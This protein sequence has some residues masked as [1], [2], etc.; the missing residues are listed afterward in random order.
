VD[1]TKPVIELALPR[2]DQAVNGAFTLAGTVRDAVGIKRL[3][4]DFAGTTK[5]EIPLRAG[6]PYF[7][8]ELDALPLKGPTA[9]IVLVAED[10]IGNKTV[11]AIAPKIDRE[12]DKPR[13]LPVFPQSEGRVRAGEQVWGTV[14]D[15]DGVASVRWSVDGGAPAEAPAAEAFAFDLPDLASGRHLL[16]LTAVDIK[17]TS[18]NPKLLP[19][20]YDRGR[21]S[22]SFGRLAAA[23]GSKAPTAGRDFSQGIEVAV[24]GGEAL[25]GIV[26]MPNPPAKAEWRIGEGQARKLEL[27][28]REKGGKEARGGDWG[29]RIPLDRSLPFGFAA[30]SVRVQDSF[31]NEAAGEA[32]IYV[33]NY[34]A[35]REETGFRF[36][37]GRAA[38]D[39]SIR[40]G[41]RDTLGGVFFREKLASLK[42]EPPTQLVQASFAGQIVTIAAANE[43]RTGLTR[44]VAMT[45]R[46]HVFS[47]GPFDFVTDLEPPAVS[48]DS[49]GQGAWV[50]D[51]LPVSGR[52]D[53]RNGLA[54][55]SWRLLPDGMKTEL[56][57]AADGRFSFTLGPAEL[58]GLSG[59]AT[60]E[61]EALDASGNAG[62]A[63][64]AFGVS[65]E[66]PKL[67]FICPESGAEVW[68]PEDIAAAISAAS[69]I[70][71]VEY[72]DDGM[73]FAAI[74][75]ADGYFAHR[76]DLAAHPLATY[77]V[78]DRAGNAA[79]ARPQVRI[80]PAP[81]LPP[82]GSPTQAG[83]PSIVLLSPAKPGA[84]YPGRLPL[85]LKI[86]APGGLASAE[87]ATGADKKPL[88][89]DEGGRYFV[90]MLDPAAAAKSGPLAILVSAKDAAGKTA[91]LSLRLGYDAM[92][93]TPRPVLGL[94]EARYLAAGSLLSCE[95]ADDDGPCE[96]GLSIDGAETARSAAGSIAIALPALAA[97]KHVLSLEARDAA[98]RSAGIKKEILALGPAPSLGAIE[99]GDAKTKLPWVPGLPVALA[100]ASYLSGQ[101]E[102]PN[103]IAA[104][105]CRIGDRQLPVSVGKAAT[106][107]GSVPFSLA[108]PQQGFGPLTLSLKARDAAGLSGSRELLIVSVMTAAAGEDDA[109]GLR[110]ADARI[111]RA[112]PSVLLSPGDTL[113]GRFKGRG[114]RSVA[115]KPAT[116][117][118]EAGFE[119]PIVSLRAKAEGIT[120][121]TTVRV[122]TVDGDAFEW[123]PAVFRIDA[124]PPELELAS[125]A[126]GLWVQESLRIAG[127]ARDPLGLAFVGYSIDGGEPQELPPAQP[128]AAGP[129]A[130]GFRFDQAIQLPESDGA[131][132]VEVVARDRTGKES[133]AA[134]LFAKDTRP[135]LISQVLP[136][137]GSSVNGLFTFVAEASDEGR[138][139]TIVFGKSEEVEG[140]GTF[141]KSLDANR[142]DFPLAEGSL[143]V[144][145]DKAGNASAFSPELSVDSEADLPVAAIHVPL[146][147]EVLRQDF[148]V[149]GAAYDDDGLA[150]VYYRLDGGEWTRLALEGQSFSLLLGLLATG[151]N[152]HRVEVKAEDVYGIV[153]KSVSRKFRIST[154]EPFARLV[155]PPSAKVLS[156]IV[157]LE[158]SASDANGVSAMAL[159]FDS[160]ASFQAPAGSAS[161]RYR[162]D[163]RLLD[164]GARAISL[165]P[166]DGYDTVGFTAALLT[167]DNS[168]PEAALDLPLDGSEAARELLVSGRVS[169]N[170]GLSSARVEILPA[171]QTQSVLSADIGTGRVVRKVLD[172]SGLK[173]GVYTVRLV[174]RDRAGNESLA[175]RDIRV[176][177]ALPEDSIEVLYP[178]PGSSVAGAIG[179][180]GRARIA[181]PPASIEIL[182]DGQ[183]VASAASGPHGYFS[184][185]LPPEA[186]A[187][188]AHRLGAR[189]IA[190]DGRAITAPERAL[191]WKR[192]GP[193]VRIESLKTGDFVPARPYLR[194]KAGMLRDAPDPSDA[195]AV[196]EFR[197]GLKDRSVASVELSLDGGLSYH[198]AEGKENWRFRMETQD[199]REGQLH[200][201]VRASFGDGSSA[202]TATILS[203][204]KTAPRV[205]MLSPREGE[206]QNEKIIVIGST[207]D[208]SG[209]ESVALALRKGDKKSYQLPAFIQ[210][211]YVDGH[212]LGATTW[213]AGLGLTFF[214]DNVKLQGDYG[215]APTTDANGQAQ[216]FFGTVFGAKLIANL[217]YVPFNYLFGPDWEFLSFSFGLGANFTYFSET[218]SGSGLLVGAVF[219]QIEFPKIVMRNWG[220]F[221]KFSFYTEA[222]VWVLS[223]VVDGGFIPKL[224]FGARIGVF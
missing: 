78:T 112:G 44:L 205:E 86:E 193:W 168:P 39:G 217:A 18:G 160:G 213:E 114:I 148:L 147:D 79:L 209:I 45:E 57:P 88:P 146:E 170:L 188:G 145:K 60:L 59:R 199:Y 202:S 74:D 208:S 128:S 127:L 20:S 122:E 104:V 192:T 132:R 204:D 216:S 166:V 180:S 33:T 77:R 179:V 90:L 28:A 55:I 13:V 100:S 95:A 130:A 111:D 9:P 15:D 6:D 73:S 87:L 153:G 131:H 47:A 69:G 43:G 101:V 212:F 52:A 222:Q 174:A 99:I 64:I 141:R 102:A 191:D 49:P 24:D 206:L 151:D 72:S 125:P 76:A 137:P 65:N 181:G 36:E 58:S 91:S 61:V 152:E 117:L 163:T 182:L 184:A 113:S 67:D 200:I 12:A 83:A 164:D 133:R 223:S 98:G 165:R 30:L 53:D 107:G 66:A 16:S 203:L 175:S 27:A 23:P 37:E 218:Q 158:G 171:G 140:L 198:R 134:R 194:G 154:E 110:F 51:R 94:P 54:R 50:K 35:D 126:D 207:S 56:K 135:P 46:G 93:D 173:T 103:G 149:S 119:G 38:G 190:A 32:L 5:G 11:L 142:L 115:L 177:G 118:L 108:L 92:A 187:E 7:A 138:V 106:P 159:S 201:V 157:E 210:G 129:G 144:A 4:Y 48:V 215:S 189:A 41:P 89:V 96:L 155:S 211:L 84:A 214:D 161:W 68:G 162:F 197:K 185:E 219:G 186:L 75:Y 14:S 22:V 139:S 31:G 195:K 123:G 70:A 121:A 85:A 62:R 105:E 17:G 42:F 8:L 82:S 10:R 150:A 19:F 40:L 109:D 3:S 116:D 2:S 21:G 63:C 183:A 221:R 29:F 97:G 80:A 124:G 178:L 156:G 1:N 143:F 176:T 34:A 167:V 81:S 26:S 25:E 169:D 172:I 136:A 196:A 71:S 220:A 224:S 120:A